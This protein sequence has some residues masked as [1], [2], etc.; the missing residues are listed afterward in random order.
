MTKKGVTNTK[1]ERLTSESVIANLEKKLSSMVESERKAYF[2]KLGFVPK[3][4]INSDNVL[5]NDNS[6]NVII[7]FRKNFKFHRLIHHDDK[8]SKKFYIMQNS[9][10]HKIDS[11]AKKPKYV[12]CAK[13]DSD[14]EQIKTITKQKTTDN[15]NK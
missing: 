2:E 1:E 5:S 14:F 7:T 13:K 6:N 11:K 8:E 9:V 10:L 12:A 15:S 3:D 4:D